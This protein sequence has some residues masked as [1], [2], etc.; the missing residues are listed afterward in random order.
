MA[1][2]P[3]M[4]G[5]RQPTSFEVSINLTTAKTLARRI[6]LNRTEPVY[7]VSQSHR[8]SRCQNVIP[9]C[10]NQ[11]QARKGIAGTLYTFRK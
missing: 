10:I 11:N 2:R 8:C 1:L 4:R 5:R 7:A 3:C 6:A 9:A